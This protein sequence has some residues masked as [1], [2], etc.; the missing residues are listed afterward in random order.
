VQVGDDLELAPTLGAGEGID[1]EDLRDEPYAEFGIIN[2][3]Q[4]GE[5]RFAGGAGWSS[6]SVPG[7]GLAR[8]A[9]RA[10]FA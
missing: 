3:T 10:R 5:R 9:P 6:A 7:C 4:L 1:V 2:R 8:R